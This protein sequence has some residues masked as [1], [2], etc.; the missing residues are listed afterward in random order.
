MGEMQKELSSRYDRDFVNG[1]RCCRTPEEAAAEGVLHLILASHALHTTHVATLRGRPPAA[2]S[3]PTVEV[4]L[5]ER[6]LPEFV[7]ERGGGN[8]LL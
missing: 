7:F 5:V 8:L 1:G 6:R 3:P 2:V 4:R